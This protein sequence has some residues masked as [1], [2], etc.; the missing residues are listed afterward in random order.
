MIEATGI[1]AQPRPRRRRSRSAQRARRARGA[2][3]TPACN[4]SRPAS[5]GRSG[6][7]V[8]SAQA[9][10]EPVKLLAELGRELRTELRIVARGSAASVASSRRG[11]P[12]S[13]SCMS[14][15]LMSRPVVRCRPSPTGGNSPISVSTASARALAAAEDPRQHARVLAVSGPEELAVRAL[16]EPVDVED[17]RQLARPHAR[18]GSAS[19]ASS[20]PC[21]SRRT[22]ASPSGRTAACPTAPVAAA[23]VSEDMIEPRNTPCSQSR[24]SCT[25]GT[26]R[27]AAAAEQEG[28]DRHAGGVL[29]LRRD[30]GALRCRRRETRVGVRG[31]GLRLGRPVVALPV[32]RVRGRLA[33]QPLP[34]DVAVVGE[35]A[36]GE[37]RVAADRVDRVGV[38]AAR[39]CRARRR[40]SRT[41]G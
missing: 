26:T 30:R 33:R 35:R 4:A 17:L 6:S 8:A 38:G 9:L 23:V 22:A 27:R 18:R 10:L 41:P 21:C 5:D 19:A 16:A 14:A 31:R 39:R 20:R 37:D 11:R 3:T 1:S 34:P 40:R 29:P 7:A 2:A 15:S 13:S 25:S 36:V 32:D 24:A 28:V 12:L